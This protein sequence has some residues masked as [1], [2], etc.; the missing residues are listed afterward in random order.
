MTA[1]GTYRR[2]QELAP[3]ISKLRNAYCNSAILDAFG[4]ALA[5]RPLPDDPTWGTRLELQ[6]ARLKAA[7]AAQA[8]G[9]ETAGHGE[10]HETRLQLARE[11]LDL[12]EGGG[13]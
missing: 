12:A 3:V 9:V 2:L 5:V 6:M 1:L 13:S 10:S 4:E 11:A 7:L 8:E